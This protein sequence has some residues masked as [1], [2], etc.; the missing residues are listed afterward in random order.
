MNTHTHTHCLALWLTLPVAGGA[1][2][3]Y[4]FQLLFYPPVSF[5]KRIKKLE[6]LLQTRH[7]ML[8]PLYQCFLTVICVSDLSV[9]SETRTKKNKKWFSSFACF[10]FSDHVCSN[11]HFSGFGDVTRGTR[12]FPRLRSKTPP[13]QCWLCPLRPPSKNA[14]PNKASI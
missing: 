14:N 6:N 2:R 8:I 13:A 3:T 5:W 4:Q 7:I 10:T 9:N 11:T 12:T 1:A